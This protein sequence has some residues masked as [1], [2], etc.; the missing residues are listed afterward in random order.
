MMDMTGHFLSGWEKSKHVDLGVGLCGGSPSV[1]PWR[2][3][4]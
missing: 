2:K 1:K 3:Y 4:S